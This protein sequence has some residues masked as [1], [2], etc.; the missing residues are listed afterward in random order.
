MAKAQRRS[1]A[2]KVTCEDCFFRQNLLCAASSFIRCC[3][4]RKNSSRLTMAAT[5]KGV[6][7]TWTRTA[8][9][10]RSFLSL[11]KNLKKPWT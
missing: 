5:M 11:S 8:Y 7:G 3:A 9:R 2:R 6:P 4:G 10:C 1:A